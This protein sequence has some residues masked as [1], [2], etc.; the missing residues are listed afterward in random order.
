MVHGAGG[1]DKYLVLLCCLCGITLPLELFK[2]FRHQS[3]IWLGDAQY[4]GADCYRKWPCSADFCVCHSTL[5]FSM[6][7]LNQV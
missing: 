3:E 6:I 5:K 2:D 7:G 1:R 4:H